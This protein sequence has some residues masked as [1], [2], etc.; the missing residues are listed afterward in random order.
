[1]E[2]A[3]ECVASFQI[4]NSTDPN[5]INNKKYYLGE[6]GLSEVEILHAGRE[7]AHL[8]PTAEIIKVEL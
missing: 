3:A 8:S 5:M 1:M 2:K 4:L 6:V 7:E